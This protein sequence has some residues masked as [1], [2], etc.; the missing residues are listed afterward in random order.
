MNGTNWIVGA[1]GW[2]VAA[3]LAALTGAAWAW[4]MPRGPIT[5]PQAVGSLAGTFVLGVAAGLVTGRRRSGLLAALAFAATFEVVRLVVIGI[6]GPTVGALSLGSTY[7]LIAF[8][9]GRGVDALLLLAPILVGA[10]WGVEAGAR[11]G[12][13]GVARMGLPALAVTGLATLAL[14]ALGV[15]LALPVSTAP[16]FTADGRPLDGS[17]AEIA[18]VRIG[19]HDQA[20][21]IRGRSTRQPRAAVPRRRARWHRSRRDACG[22]RARAGLRRGHLGAARRGQVVCRARPGLDAHRRL[23]GRGHARAHRLPP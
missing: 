18:N 2:L 20:V 3:V 10:A 14:V 5:A 23:D 9:L 17:V 22:C 21:M 15:Q 1:R 19:G 7:G 6:T 11:I 16:V 13:P 8:A 4:L 12:L